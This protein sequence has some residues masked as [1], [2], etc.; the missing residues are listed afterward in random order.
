MSMKK[1][2]YFDIMRGGSTTTIDPVNTSINFVEFK[3]EIPNFINSLI[4]QEY[5]SRYDTSLSQIKTKIDNFSGEYKNAKNDYLNAII[6]YNKEE[7][8]KLADK[9]NT[10]DYKNLLV[11][12]KYLLRELTNLQGRK[13]QLDDQISKINNSSDSDSDKQKRI[14]DLTSKMITS[15]LNLNQISNMIDSTQTRLNEKLKEIENLKEVQEKVIENELQNRENEKKAKEE[16]F[17]SVKDSTET[18]DKEVDEFNRS[19]TTDYNQLKEYFEQVDTSYNLAVHNAGT[20]DIYRDQGQNE[21]LDQ[22]QIFK[23]GVE[24]KLKEM[25]SKKTKAQELISLV[26]KTFGSIESQQFIDEKQKIIETYATFINSVQQY[27]NTLNAEAVDYS[28]A[29][30]EFIK[31]VMNETAQERNDPFIQEIF[32]NLKKLFDIGNDIEKITNDITTQERYKNVFEDRLVSSIKK[33]QKQIAILDMNVIKIKLKELKNFKISLYDKKRID[34]LDIRV[35]ELEKDI[36]TYKTN[37]EKSITE[38]E[39]MI[40][41]LADLKKIKKTLNF[42][43]GDLIDTYTANLEKVN[44]L[45]NLEGI[46]TQEKK[47]TEEDKLSKLQLENIEKVIRVISDS[48]ARENIDEIMGIIDGTGTGD[49]QIGG[50]VSNK[51]N[52]SI[53]QMSQKMSIFN[54]KEFHLLFT[55]MSEEE[56]FK[57]FCEKVLG[58]YKESILLILN[59]IFINNNNNNNNNNNVDY[60]YNRDKKYYETYYDFANNNNF[61]SIQSNT[62]L[63]EYTNKLT[64]P[65]FL[66]TYIKLEE[67]QAQNVDNSDLV[68]KC[69]V[70]EKIHKILSKPNIFKHL[71]IIYNMLIKKICPIYTFVKIRQDTNEPNPRYEL[72]SKIDIKE[73]YSEDNLDPNDVALTIKYYNSD[74]A[75]IFS[76]Q[77]VVTNNDELNTFKNSATVENY[78]VGPV[79]GFFTSSSNNATIAKDVVIDKNITQKLLDGKDVIIIGNGQSGSGKTSTLVYL[80]TNNGIEQDGI[81][82]IMCNDSKIHKEFNTLKVRAVEIYVK[83]DSNIIDYKQIKPEHYFVQNLRLNDDDIRSKKKS[84]DFEKGTLHSGEQK[85]TTWLYEGK[86]LSVVINQ[87]LNRRLIGPTKNNPDSSRSHVLILVEFF[88]SGESL[89]KSKMVICDL[90]GVEDRFKCGISD[91][92]TSF[93]R[94]TTSNTHYLKTGSIQ[95]D[96]NVAKC[97]PINL[98]NADEPYKQKGGLEPIVFNEYNNYEEQKFNPQKYRKKISHVEYK[99]NKEINFD[100]RG[101]EEVNTNRKKDYNMLKIIMQKYASTYPHQ[102]SD[103]QSFINKFF[104]MPDTSNNLWTTF[105]GDSSIT[106][107]IVKKL[108]NNTDL[109]QLLEYMLYNC[110]VRRYEGYI[111]NKSLGEMRNLIT[112]LTYGIVKAKLYKQENPLFFLIPSVWNDKIYCYGDNYKNDDNYKYFYSD[113]EF[114]P[115]ESVIFNIMFGKEN[116]ENTTNTLKCN[117]SDNLDTSDPVERF[118]L[119]LTNVSISLVTL[120]NLTASPTINNPPNPPYINVNKLKQIINI[121]KYFKQIKKVRPQFYLDSFN[122]IFTPVLEKIRDYLVGKYTTIDDL[123]ESDPPSEA[124]QEDLKGILNIIRTS[125]N[126]NLKNYVKSEKFKG[127]VAT[128]LQN[129]ELIKF[130]N[131]I[132]DG[133]ELT[134]EQLLSKNLQYGERFKVKKSENSEG[135]YSIGNITSIYKIMKLNLLNISHFN[136]IANSYGFYKNTFGIN[137]VLKRLYT[138]DKLKVGGKWGA[139][140]ANKDLDITINIFKLFIEIKTDDLQIENNI[141]KYIKDIFPNDTTPSTIDILDL[142]LALANKVLETIESSNPAT[143]IGTVDFQEYTQFRDIEKLYMTCDGQDNSYQLDI[144]ANK[145]FA[146]N[147]QGGNNIK[148]IDLA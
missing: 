105:V 137:E 124:I 58:S 47:K 51:P 125:T 128:L 32:Q 33:I 106:D 11:D 5:D 129:N 127:K 38:R 122:A 145:D 68:N 130:N 117:N 97:S 110:L 28:K 135:Y 16:K 132:N 71:K 99:N 133:E 118:D 101:N 146:G 138:I 98:S 78:Y 119:S 108:S 112:N 57:L 40:K 69:H 61:K 37:A 53:E 88:K 66:S 111:I 73:S 6:T 7:A 72:T 27:T 87:L 25:E 107:N 18:I 64:N 140:Y 80:K 82:P 126:I 3:M 59:T 109:K 22:V 144:I 35:A 43:M 46:E 134:E 1:Y 12:R 70:L 67:T 45:I 100:T 103:L 90:A 50:T 4:N 139:Y 34:L 102:T 92:I 48:E 14:S 148:W 75:L 15:N 31:Q 44:E 86:K 60:L 141:K 123:I 79:T 84:Y 42:A 74:E 113:N 54:T 52:I 143:L 9:L 131:Q 115:S 10:Q 65:L 23:N 89:A 147:Q 83:W 13:K 20:A 116:I 24:K 29:N 96:N 26:K 41:E 56:Y 93:D 39:T 91:I 30:N 62:K 21:A 2:K 19:V 55:I 36:S 76:N 81:I 120:I 49:Q 136:K 95:L 77:G 142:Y 94:L 104:N 121:L 114:K 17:K 8:E 85:E 63:I